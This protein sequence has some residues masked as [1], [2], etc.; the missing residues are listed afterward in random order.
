[1]RRLRLSSARFLWPGDGGRCGGAS[2]LVGG[3]RGGAERRG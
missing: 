2:Q 1:L 3:A